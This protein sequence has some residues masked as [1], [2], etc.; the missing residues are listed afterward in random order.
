MAIEFI[1]MIGTR[2]ASEL[3]GP[4]ANLIG[5]HVDAQFVKEFALAH[6]NS[7]FDRVLI[8]YGSTG[9]DG[10]S[11][12]SYV[13]SVTERLSFLI[14]HRPGFVAPT[15]AARKAATLDHFSG[16]R[17]ALHIITGG[18]D[19]EQQRDGDWLEKDARYRRSDEYLEIVRR[20]WTETAPFDYEGEFYHVKRASSEV[21]PLQQP[22]LPIY[23]GGMS[24]PAVPVG[25]KHADVYAMWGEPVASV[26]QVI[27]DVR[28]EAAKWG[29]SPRFSVSLRPIIAPT[30]ELAWEKAHGYLDRILSLRQPG[31]GAPHPS[32]KPQ[33]AGSQ[34]LLELA[35]R[36]EVHDTRLWTAIAA[37]VG[38]YGNTTALVGTPE[39]VAESMLAYYDAG[40]TTLL[41][42]GFE[43]LPDAV[44]Y[45]RELIP[46][47]R[48]GVAEREKRA[49]AMGAAR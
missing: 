2:S 47:V 46:L 40:V 18:N 24:G 44:E 39:Q 45:G 23:F 20:T 4:G 28:T 37:A 8:G 36:G 16:G 3:D 11:V 13:A 7:D 26:K 10:F 31:N 22:H 34:R 33:A 43:P 9:P 32:Y 15:L 35:E 27:A 42:R 12:A 49:A 41:I 29:R 30:E 19:A 17:I 6:E 38:A 21:K 5:G 25:A 14:A 1:G 48:A